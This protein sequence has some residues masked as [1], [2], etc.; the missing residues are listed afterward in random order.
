MSC[1]HP[2]FQVRA[3]A[4]TKILKKYKDNKV[5]STDHFSCGVQQDSISVFCPDCKQEWEFGG[6]FELDD[7]MAENEIIRRAVEEIQCE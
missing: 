2:N 7:L 4:D 6:D 3:Y 1:K 5:V